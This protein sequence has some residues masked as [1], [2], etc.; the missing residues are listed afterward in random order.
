MY[1]TACADTRYDVKKFSYYYY[2]II[3]LYYYIIIK[4]KSNFLLSID[5]QLYGQRI[6][7]NLSL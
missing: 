6:K 4:I 5:N 3:L 1:S 2:I 7:K